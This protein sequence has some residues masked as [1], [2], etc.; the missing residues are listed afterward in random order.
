[1]N[2]GELIDALNEYDHLD[3]VLVPSGNGGFDDVRIVYC[4]MA[5]MDFYTK[6]YGEN[7]GPHEYADN[8]LDED[9][10]EEVVFLNFDGSL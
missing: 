7:I 2:V 5:Y 10:Q 4:D 6:T 9:K 3:P 8:D 1:M